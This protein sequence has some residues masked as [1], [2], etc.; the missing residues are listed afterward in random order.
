[1]SQATIDRIMGALLRKRPLTGA[2]L[3]LARHEIE[4]LVAELLEPK[5]SAPAAR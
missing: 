2:Q 1:M 5:P 4:R 3:Q